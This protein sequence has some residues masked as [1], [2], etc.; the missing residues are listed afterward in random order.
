MEVGVTTAGMEVGV[1]SVG[2]EVG[3]ASVVHIAAAGTVVVG[4]GLI[5]S[6]LSAHV[7]GM[8]LGIDTGVGTVIVEIAEED[9]EGSG[10]DGTSERSTR[11]M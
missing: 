4:M 10:K 3:V 7:L 5:N 6:R 11:G 8:V 2:M 1:A 9:V